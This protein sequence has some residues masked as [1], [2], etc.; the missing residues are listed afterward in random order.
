MISIIGAG[1]AGSYLASLLAKQE[2]V[3]VFEEH[4]KI[5]LPV[6][7]TG[8]TTKALAELLHIDKRFLVNKITNAKIIAPNWNCLDIKLNKPNLIIDRMKFD[9]HLAEKAQDRGVKFYL[10]H[11]YK[12]CVR[13]K[14][15]LEIHFSG[16]KNRF[17]TDILVGADGPFSQ[18]AKTTGLWRERKFAIGVQAR[19]NIKT[20]PETVEFYVNQGQFGWIVPESENTARVGVASYVHP[21]ERFKTFLKRRGI[22]KCK[23]K[24]YQ[25]GVIPLYDSKL[26][27]QDRNVYLLGDAATH[28]KATTFG[29]IVQGLIA[30]EELSKAI[31]HK[32]N[33]E[34][35][36]RKRIGLDLRIGL[37]IRKKLDKFSDEDYNSL[38]R[39]LNNSGAKKVL[40]SHERD[41]PAKL[42]LKMLIKEPGLLKFAFM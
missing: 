14:K 33:Y 8:I 3:T 27:T 23:V 13:N 28:V 36:W 11:K 6:Q 26:R 20:D 18:V 19:M 32:K 24:E 9:S 16:K 42:V 31:L 5:G 21:N 17:Q 1:P 7:C 25:S 30:A 35:L 2:E 40:E 38:I 41:F 12:S 4:E 15:E 10:N 29:G 34:T 37:M 39:V 22:D